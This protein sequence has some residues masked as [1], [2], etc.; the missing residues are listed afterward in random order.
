MCVGLLRAG[1]STGHCAFGLQEGIYK[2]RRA[3]GDARWGK[4]S[5]VWILALCFAVCFDMGFRARG[6]GV[7]VLLGA[8]QELCAVRGPSAASRP[9]P[10]SVQSRG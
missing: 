1:S 5:A 4:V 6:C 7:L 10:V 3:G 9:S 2:K 8:G